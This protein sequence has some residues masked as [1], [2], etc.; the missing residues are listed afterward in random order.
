MKLDFRGRTYRMPLSPSFP[1]LTAAL[2]LKFRVAVPR[3]HQ[4]TWTDDDGDAV[5]VEAESDWKVFLSACAGAPRLLLQPRYRHTLSNDTVAT[6]GYLSSYSWEMNQTMRDFQ[7]WT[8][9]FTIRSERGEQSSFSQQATPSV[10]SEP[11]DHFKF[12]D[13]GEKESP[14]SP[15]AAFLQQIVHLLLW[16]IW[17]SALRDT[18]E[19]SNHF[20]PR[21]PTPRQRPRGLSI[22][23]S[24][25][26]FS[27][28]VSENS[29]V[30]GQSCLPSSTHSSGFRTPARTLNILISEPQ[31]AS[32]LSS[33]N[34]DDRGLPQSSLETSLHLDEGSCDNSKV[35]W[36]EE[37]LRMELVEAATQVQ[38]PD[39]LCHL[40]LRIRKLD[41]KK[42]PTHLLRL[43]SVESFL[44]Q[45]V[46]VSLGACP[47]TAGVVSVL[48]PLAVTPRQL[49]LTKKPLIKFR[50][51][52]CDAGR[53]TL[54]QSNAVLVAVGGGEAGRG[55]FLSQ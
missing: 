42:W 5:L 22:C 11:A 55:R 39:G 27:T 9:R 45:Q 17:G 16:R 20:Q 7:G 52:G 46:R 44:P 3:D 48:V 35:N 26:T 32:P 13:F 1:A 15:G 10:Q 53:A 33:L 49:L 41:R 29:L 19:C 40:A 4:L 37:R 54:F 34:M 25:P 43:E 38:T 31:T 47:E 6:L 18:L 14:D 30:V 21:S 50:L 24:A 12:F 28:V 23:D 36:L 2:L 8:P 51:F